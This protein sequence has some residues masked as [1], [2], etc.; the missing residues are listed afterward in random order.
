[1]NILTKLFLPVIFAVALGANTASAASPWVADAFA[2]PTIGKQKVGVAF[3]TIENRSNMPTRLVRVDSPQAGRVELH[4]HQMEG[5][6]MRMRKIDGI[7]LAS[8]GKI[9]MEGG[10]LH[11]MMFDL[12]SALKVGDK[13]DIN[14]Y[15]DDG[16]ELGV[17]VPVRKRG[18]AA[19][20]K[21]A[22]AHLHHHA[23]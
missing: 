17:M 3:I 5:D 19:H 7:D 15:F 10:G 16:T 4:T 22:A 11:L 20:K 6:I 23:H 18:H 12:K 13:L 2:K 1:M 9:K 8:F 14:L 21:D